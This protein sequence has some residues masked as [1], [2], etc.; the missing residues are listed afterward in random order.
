MPNQVQAKRIIS[1]KDVISQLGIS[2]S[3]LYNLVRNGYFPKGIPLGARKIGWLQSDVDEF[4]Q[5]QIKK[6][7][8]VKQVS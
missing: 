5:K 4:I 3:G 1:I 7:R 8:Y 6:S 2:R